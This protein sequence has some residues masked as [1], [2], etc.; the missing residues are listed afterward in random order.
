MQVAEILHLQGEPTSAKHET[1]NS[2]SVERIQNFNH[3]FQKKPKWA[4]QVTQKH[5]ALNAQDHA[6][7]GNQIRNSLQH[8]GMARQKMAPACWSSLEHRHD[9]QQQLIE[10]QKRQLQEQQELILKLQENVRLKMTRGETE[11]VTGDTLTLTNRVRKAR[12]R[13]E[14]NV[15]NTEPLRYS[16][17]TSVPFTSISTM[18]CWAW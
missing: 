8:L 18:W 3:H 9:F 6:M 2:D 5:A 12:E 4:W 10:E 13:K 14:S 7:F 17:D 1:V 11:E 15:K 16:A